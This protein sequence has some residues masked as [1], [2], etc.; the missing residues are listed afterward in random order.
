MQIGTI[1]IVELPEGVMVAFECPERPDQTDAEVAVAKAISDWTAS[2][3]LHRVVQQTKKGKNYGKTE[4]D[5]TGN[6][7][8]R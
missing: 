7:R 8:G 3:D 6:R 1:K 4:S 5:G 2:E